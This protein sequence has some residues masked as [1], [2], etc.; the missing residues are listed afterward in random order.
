MTQRDLWNERYRENEAVWGPGPNELVAERLADIEP[1]RVLDLGCGQGRN[2]IWLAA[3][4]HAV[5]G[6]DV[7]DVA[8][9]QAMK[10]AADAGIEADF[11]AEDLLRWEPPASAFDLVLLAYMQAP[12]PLRQGLHRKAAEALAPGGRVFL[13][14]HHKDNLEHGVGGPQSLDYLF[15]GESVAADFADF[16]VEENARVTR[17]VGDGDTAGTAIDLLFIARKP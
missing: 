12:D 11:I 3:G 7:S 1:C 5:T 6:I 4:G 17:V 16:D 14:A 15:D 13:V 10:L 9:G 2:A 8:I